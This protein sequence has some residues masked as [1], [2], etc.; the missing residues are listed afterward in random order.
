MKETIASLR[1]PWNLIF[2]LEPLETSEN[3][4]N[5]I[6]VHASYKKS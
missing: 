5:P 1:N 4:K 3:K 2:P 6:K